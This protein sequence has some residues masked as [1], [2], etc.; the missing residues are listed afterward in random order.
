MAK[1][2]RRCA[3]AVVFNKQGKVLLGSRIECKTDAWQFP[4]GGIETGESPEEAAKRELFEET[5]ISSVETVYVTNAPVRYEFTQ[6][7]KNN[8][9]KRGIFN[10]GQDIYFA[11]FYF[12]GQDSEINLQ[13]PNPEFKKYMWGD[14]DFAVKNVVDFKREPYLKI[15]DKFVFEIKQYLNKLS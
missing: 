3:G 15:K 4:Q 13:T 2:F 14:L 11:L 7:I 10:D 9:H 1:Q 8:F 12:T 5:S 6:D